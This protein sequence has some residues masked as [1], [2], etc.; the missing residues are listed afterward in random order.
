MFFNGTGSN[1]SI[2]DN[3]NFAKYAGGTGCIKRP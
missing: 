1:C 2:A 3:S